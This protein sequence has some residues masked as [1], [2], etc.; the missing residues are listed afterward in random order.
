[1]AGTEDPV[2]GADVGLLS[3]V[4]AA[5]LVAA[6]TGDQAVLA[7]ILAVESGWAAVLEKAYIADQPGR[8][9]LHAAAGAPRNTVHAVL[10]DLKGTSSATWAR[11]P[12]SPVAFLP[13]TWNF[14]TGYA[15]TDANGAQCG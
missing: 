8:A 9:A 6:L 14:H 11:P 5:P 3:P 7:A 2:T 1:M 10:A 4:T 13:P 15:E 12:G